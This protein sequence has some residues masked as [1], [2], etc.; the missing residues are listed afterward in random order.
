MGA[1][2]LPY[3]FV[4][5]QTPTQTQWNSNPT[6]IATLVNGQIDKANVDSSGSDGIVTMDETQTV[7][8]A[9]TW[10]GAAQF[11]AAVTVGVD[12]TG[13]DVQLFGDT[14]GAHLLWDESADDLKLVGAAGLTVAG[15]SALNVTTTTTLAASTITGS[16]V[17]RINDTTESTSTTTGSLQTDGGIAWVKDAYV[18]DDMYFTS[19]AILDF[20]SD[21]T[22]TH[23][24]NTLTVAG[25]TWATAALTASTITGSGVLRINDVTESTSTTT[26]SLQ[27]AGGI[28]WVKDAYVGDDMYFTSGAILDFNSG[29]ETLTHAANKL[30]FAG[31]D[32]HVADGVVIGH[33]AQVEPYTVVPEFQ[34]LG[35]ATA[36][37]SM[38]IARY[39]NNASGPQLYFLKSRGTTIGGSGAV[40]T[41]GDDYGT[42]LWNGDDGNDLNSLAAI[43]RVEADGASSENVTPGRMM[44][45]TTPDASATPIER[46]RIDSAGNVTKPTNVY[47]N[48]AM[49]SGPT[50]VTGDGTVYTVV[51]DTEHDDIGGNVS[52]GVFTAPVTGRYL[53]TTSV[54]LTGFTD[55]T[56][57]Q[58]SIFT[59]SRTYYGYPLGDLEAGEGN[60][61]HP[62]TV[63]AD[64]DAND[65]AYSRVAVGG[66]SGS[67]VIDINTTAVASWF[68]GYLLG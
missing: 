31:G 41:A 32:F 36:D 49:A 23:S 14:A 9:K 3:T 63:I 17:L 25:G 66:G 47:F 55:H 57:L 68:H 28:A 60:Q 4:A 16:G 51:W 56:W 7:S 39:S 64:M 58:P 1:I 42:I 34:V 12:G 62:V 30:T 19:G 40:T 54:Q 8:G 20:A 15:T 27:T 2:T 52:S 21:V 24:S 33:T 43:L 29:A 38:V 48:L 37:S 45:F 26:G 65:T 35:T 67:K 13:Y 59:T 22:I 6:T 5:G 46:M 10:T 50:N 61:S 44:F 11:S 18:G 53:L